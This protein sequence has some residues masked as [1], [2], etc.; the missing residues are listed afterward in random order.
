MNRRKKI[1]QI[2]QPWHGLIH[3]PPYMDCRTVKP[4]SYKTLPEQAEEIREKAHKKF[5]Q[6]KIVS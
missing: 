3:I 2:E 5:P 6:L 4:F 1:I